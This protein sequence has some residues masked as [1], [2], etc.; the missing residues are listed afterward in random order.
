MIRY[1]IDQFNVPGI[2]VYADNAFVSVEMC[3]W[4]RMN[5]VNL[6]GTTRRGRGFPDDLTYSNLA[7]GGVVCMFVR[8]DCMHYIRFCFTHNYVHAL[9]IPIIAIICT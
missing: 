1:V 5:G 6:C 7:V 8:Y 3:R 4:C 9:H 2:M